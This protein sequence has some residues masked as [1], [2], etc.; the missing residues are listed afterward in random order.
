MGPGRGGPAG[1][2]GPGR[3]GSAA[4]APG[5][6]VLPA[7]AGAPAG[8]GAGAAVPRKRLPDGPLKAGSNGGWHADFIFVGP[9]CCPTRDVVVD[10]CRR[11]EPW[12]WVCVT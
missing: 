11:N 3:D 9:V 4:A 2:G 1:A 10:A 12:I 5:A 8:A 6:A 7:E